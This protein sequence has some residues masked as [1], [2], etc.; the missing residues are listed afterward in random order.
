LERV[1]EMEPGLGLVVTLPAGRVTLQTPN[2]NA[3]VAAIAACLD[4]S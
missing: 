1:T 4:S 3:V 2:P